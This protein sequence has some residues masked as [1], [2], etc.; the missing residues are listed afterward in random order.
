MKAGQRPE[1]CYSGWQDDHERLN[2]NIKRNNKRGA[3]CMRLT[4]LSSENCHGFA[5]DMRLPG[6]PRP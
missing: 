2:K 5:Y 1:A 4:R 6:G 3:S